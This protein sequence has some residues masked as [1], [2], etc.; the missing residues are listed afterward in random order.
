MPLL[1]RDETISVETV[2]MPALENM[3]L[4]LNGPHLPLGFWLQSSSA[5]ADQLR[6]TT[7]IQTRR[8]VEEASLANA[9]AAPEAV[10]ALSMVTRTMLETDEGCLGICEETVHRHDAY[11]R[12][13]GVMF[14]AYEE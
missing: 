1:S 13:K 2:K 6:R 9:A 3:H 4:G 11:Y 8:E 10:A 5:L 14:D 12:M 7:N